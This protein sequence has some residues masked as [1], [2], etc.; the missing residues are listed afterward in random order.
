MK[1][2]SF[3]FDEYSTI[4][5]EE[6]RELGFEFIEAGPML[7]PV[8][9]AHRRYHH[10]IGCPGRPECP[11]CAEE[12]FYQDHHSPEIDPTPI[13]EEWLKSIGF[14]DDRAGCPTFSA[15]HIQPDSRVPQYACIRSFPIPIPKTRGDV[16]TL[17]RLLGITCGPTVVPNERR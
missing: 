1:R 5:I 11:V 10:K 3:Q 8:L 14:S 17:L 12:E 9:E 15:L 4:P 13:T 16:M 2:V 6:M 7:I